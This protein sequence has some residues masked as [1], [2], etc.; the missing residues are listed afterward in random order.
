MDTTITKEELILKV[1][2][3]SIASIDRFIEILKSNNIEVTE[4]GK[5]EYV[6]K[7]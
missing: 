2:F 4:L 7:F 3:S 6:I 5:D 1:D